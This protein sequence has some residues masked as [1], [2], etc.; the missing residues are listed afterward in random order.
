MF[1]GGAGL[2]VN[3]PGRRQ[4]QLKL[5]PSS[6]R[7]SHAWTSAPKR[8]RAAARKDLGTSSPSREAPAPRGDNRRSRH[9]PDRLVG[10]RGRYRHFDVSHRRRTRGFRLASR[11]AS[12]PASAWGAR[13]ILRT[14][15]P[16]RCPCGRGA[17]RR[18][19]DSSAFRV[20]ISEEGEQVTVVRPG[21]M[22]EP[23]RV[24]GPAHRGRGG[25]CWRHSQATGTDPRHLY[26]KDRLMG[27]HGPVQVKN[28]PRADVA[29]TSLSPVVPRALDV[30]QL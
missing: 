18:S 27:S 24:T 17:T 7:H 5:L 21:V 6:P 2:A 12:P 10:R 9:A 28:V 3:Q 30:E 1:P 20:G 8:R 11:P 19:G 16:G 22:S 15:T 29:A 14:S 23:A 25:G 26:L 4:R 13:A